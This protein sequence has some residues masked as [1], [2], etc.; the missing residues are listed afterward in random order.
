LPQEIEDKVQQENSAGGFGVALLKIFIIALLLVVLDQASKYWV[1]QNIAQPGMISVNTKRI[2]VIPGCFDLVHH[3]N[4]GAA[5]GMLQ[6]QRML[7]LLMTPIAIAVII[8]L[9]R[10]MW[11][12][13][14]RQRHWLFIWALFLGGAIGNLIDRVRGDG[15]IDFIEVYYEPIGTWPAFNVADSCICIGIA[16]MLLFSMFSGKSD[17]GEENASV[18]V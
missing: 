8:G 3:R 13:G 10:S 9:F 15:V 17:K 14:E 6:G 12:S 7:F 5:F 1:T 18:S 11:K 2:E 4:L 16:L